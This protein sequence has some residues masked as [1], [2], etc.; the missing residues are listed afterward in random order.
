VVHHISG[1]M[2]SKLLCGVRGVYQ[3]F[4]AKNEA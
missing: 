1:S 4:A 3:V 2:R